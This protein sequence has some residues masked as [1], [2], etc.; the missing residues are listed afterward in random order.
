MPFREIGSKMVEARV[1]PGQRMFSQR[2]AMIA[3]KGEVS[4]TPNIQ[5]G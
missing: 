2:G 1:A 3:Y 5:G 4:F